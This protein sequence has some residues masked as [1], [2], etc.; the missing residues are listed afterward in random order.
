MYGFLKK[1][2]LFAGLP[3]ED[4]N[5]LCEMVEE[6]HLPAGSDL[7]TEGSQGD[8]AYIIKSGQIEI[9][10]QSEG[11]E[12]LLAVRQPG[13]VIGE[14]SLLEATPRNASGRA[15][16]D[17]VLLAITHEQLN[18]LLNTSPSA[19]RAMLHTFTSRL[20][21]SELMSRQSE[22]LAQLGT[23]TAGIAHELNNPSAAAQRGAEQL[24]TA[25]DRLQS[26]LL[27]IQGSGLSEDQRNSLKELDAQARRCAVRPVN[28]SPLE[29]S[30]REYEIEIWLEGRQFENGWEY[31]PSLVN[32]GFDSTGITD[33]TSKFSD[34]QI[35]HLLSWLSAIYTI[36]S[37]LEEIRM[38]TDRISEVVNSLKSYVYLDQAPVQEVDIHEGL[39]NTLTLL[40]S[41]ASD[42]VKIHRKYADSLPRVHANGSELNQVW[43]NIIN[44]SLEAID[45][46]GQIT[47]RT[48][49]QGEW[50]IVEIR[51]NGLG[52]PAEAQSKI[53]SPFFTTKPVGKGTGLGLNISY[54]IIVKHGGDIKLFSKPG[55]TCF[56]VWLPAASDKGKNHTMPISSINRPDDG[57]LR[58]IL[59]NNRRIAVVGISER[60]ERPAYSVPAYLQSKGYQ[61]YPVNPTLQEVLGEKAYP[62]LKSVPEP[63]DIVLIFRRSDMVPPIVEDAIQVGANVVWMQEGIINEAAAVAAREAGL[64]VVMD[65]CMR[66]QH[67]RLVQKD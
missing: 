50:V 52:I 20:R 15:Q 59:I 54:N 66:A 44:N 62:D 18:Q 53:F 33:L 29:L 14:M 55:D 10:K 23:L 49:R 3:E 25:I 7:F 38:G 45:G 39:D 8:R 2:P 36:Y 58:Q 12:I 19:A 57:Q 47:L 65:T 48:H 46:Q 56:Q 51:D 34:L 63:I 9:V 60:K 41:K 32:L 30:D 27:A 40:H 31:A 17:S 37:L 1:V 16:T 64:Q 22:K 61:I 35:P 4:L 6:V 42:R 43:T 13:E 5:R 24:S 28:L 26:A 11:R 67:I 21:V